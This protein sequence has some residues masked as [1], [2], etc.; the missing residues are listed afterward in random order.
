MDSVTHLVLGAAIGEALLG[1]QLGKKA[2]LWGA[3][4]DSIP[5]LDV[6]FVPLFHPPTSLLVHRGITHSFLFLALM[7]PLFG[8]LLSRMGLKRQT[9]F[10]KWT[11]LFALG[12]FTHILIDSFTAYGTGWFEPFSHYRVTFNSIFVADLF[13]TLPLLVCAIALLFIK[14][15]PAHHPA[16]PAVEMIDRVI[17][18]QKEERVHRIM[19]RRRRWNNAGLFLSTAYLVF[20]FVNKWHVNSIFAVSLEKNKIAYTRFFTTPTPLNN[21]LWMGV[22]EAK[23]G[24]YVG[25][26][27]NFDTDKN[28]SFYRVEKNEQLLAGKDPVMVE[29]LK[30]FSNGYYCLT[31]E[32]TTTYFNDLRFGQLAGWSDPAAPFAFAFDLGKGNDQK[33]LNRGRFKGTIGENFMKLWDRIKGN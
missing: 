30:W 19:R 31:K 11:L 7:S 5:D 17:A 21:F 24:Y 26:Y 29:G 8:L 23:D 25:Y 27:S 22:A 20:T 6:F 1:K 33:A 3:L 9:S 15:I 28:V 18:D 4:A 13:Y 2:M 32:D 10:Q 14:G 12:I 16:P